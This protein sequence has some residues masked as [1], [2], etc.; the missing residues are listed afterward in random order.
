MPNRTRLEAPGLPDYLVA[1]RATED[2]AHAIVRFLKFAVGAIP[3]PAADRRGQEDAQKRSR[4]IL[5]VPTVESIL[6]EL[7]GLRDDSTRAIIA[8]GAEA[9]G[10]AAVAMYTTGNAFETYRI[11]GRK[12]D[13]QG[14]IRGVV[15]KRGSF[16][17]EVEVVR[18]ML[19]AS[20]TDLTVDMGVQEVYATHNDRDTIA[21]TVLEDEGLGFHRVSAISAE[22]LG[23]VVN[24]RIAISRLVAEAPRAAV[25]TGQVHIY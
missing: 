24:G 1:E 11:R 8:R 6:E 25:T 2:D 17:R 4:F 23:L 22:D 16:N 3:E 15:A 14:E 21:S 13:P 20:V 19:R 9:G 10:I 18:A 7:A 5:K 12:G